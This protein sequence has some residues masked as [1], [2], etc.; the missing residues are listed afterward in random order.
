MRWLCALVL[1][2]CFSTPARPRGDSGPGL[3]GTLADS[4]NTDSAAT[5]NNVVFV[6]RDTIPGVQISNVGPAD[7]FCASQANLAGLTGSFVAWVSFNGG[8]SASTRLGAARGWRRTDGEP[9]VD[10]VSDL[11]GGK[12]YSPPR[13]DQFGDEAYHDSTYVLTGTGANGTASG[14]DCAT[15]TNSTF[16]TNDAAAPLWTATSDL[17]CTTNFQLYC[18]G[19]ARTNALVVPPPAGKSIAFVSAPVGSG[20]SASGFDARCMADAAGAGLQGTFFAG[21]AVSNASAMDRVALGQQK[22]WYRRDGTKVANTSSLEL[23]APINQDA[24]GARIAAEVWFGAGTL[25]EKADTTKNCN[26]WTPADATQT[27]TG[28]TR[29]SS[30]GAF[31]GAS[32]P[33]CTTMQRVYCLQVQ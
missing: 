13:K 1:A 18:F 22:T 29:R 9:V 2:G 32:N 3:D 19:T 24:S 10:T 14:L 21:V 4:D 20:T 28:D 16:G 15:A 7:A 23:L 5:D 8:V 30:V 31:T 27:S 26:N 6:T 25:Q 11:V 33:L 12:L 17:S